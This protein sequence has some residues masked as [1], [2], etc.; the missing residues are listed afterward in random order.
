L[1]ETTTP[2]HVLHEMFQKK[3]SLTK[4]IDVFYIN[5]KTLINY[6]LSCQ[7]S[8]SMSDLILTQMLIMQVQKSK[9][10][11]NP[12]GQSIQTTRAHFEESS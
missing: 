6:S 9:T 5:S 2:G 12:Y 10:S 3:Q 1:F 4:T 8:D 7:D 11:Q